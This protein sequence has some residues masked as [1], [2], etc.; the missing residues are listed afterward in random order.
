MSHTP[1]PWKRLAAY[2]F[3][4]GKH[5]GNICVIGEPRA[6]TM[7]EYKPLSMSSKDIDEAYANARLIAAAP[8]LLA[9]LEKLYRLHCGLDSWHEDAMADAWGNDCTAIA[10]AKGEA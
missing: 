4:E 8:D 9:A 3:A 5:G 7:V 10:K 6:S 2:V 1:G